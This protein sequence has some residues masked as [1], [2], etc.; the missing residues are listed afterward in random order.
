MKGGIGF[1]WSRAEGGGGP[2]WWLQDR[3]G[4][5]AW[6]EFAASLC[7]FYLVLFAYAALAARH[8]RKSD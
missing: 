7:A 8:R 5:S 1:A 6:I 4:H 3:L 2:Y